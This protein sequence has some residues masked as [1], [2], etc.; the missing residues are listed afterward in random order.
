MIH[1]H[2]P[3]RAVLAQLPFQHK[4]HDFWWSHK[5]KKAQI[6]TPWNREH[7]VVFIHTPKCAGTSVYKTLQ[8]PRPQAG[9]HIP[10]EAYYAADAE[11]APQLDSFTFVRNPLDR[12][13]SAFHYLAFHAEGAGDQSF[14]KAFFGDE[15]DFSTFTDHFLSDRAFRN[16][17]MSHPHFRPQVHYVFSANWQHT[18]K[19]VF[20]IEDGMG[21]LAGITETLDIELAIETVNRSERSDFRQYYTDTQVEG[22]G[23]VYRE[24]S[25]RL[26]YEL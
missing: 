5:A 25:A 6:L 9:T 13:V 20:K 7:G 3:L 2:R 1:R 17:V 4:V 19:Y 24:D 15:P 23:K 18:P 8:M 10:I 22:L 21:Q 26:G 11:L 16:A 14:A 12:F